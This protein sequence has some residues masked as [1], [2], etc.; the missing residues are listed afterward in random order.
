[1]PKSNS[2]EQVILPNCVKVANIHYYP[3]LTRFEFNDGTQLTNLTIDGRNNNTII[4]YIL[5]NFVG[6]YTTNLEITNIPNNFWLSESICRKL[7][8]ITNIKIFGT[9]NIGDGVNLTDIDWT[10]K[11]MLVEKF[12]NIGSGDIVFRYK[13]IPYVKD[14]IKVNATGTIEF[15]GLAP[16]QLSIDGNEVPIDSDNKH[17]K[18]YYTI[19]D[20]STGEVPSTNDIH[21][22]NKWTPQLI[23]KEGL[24]EI[25]KNIFYLVC[26]SYEV[27]SKDDK[28][29]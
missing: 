13:S 17:L 2:V 12:G 9:I 14:D 20:K 25:D 1:M 4:E 6:S 22:V 26:D 8:Q 7:T 11:R 28:D 16:I 10:T 18:I 21:F 19:K 27:S 23:I 15:S 3:N 24:K 29:E 5:A